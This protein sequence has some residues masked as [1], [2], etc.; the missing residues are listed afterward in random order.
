MG[1]PAAPVAILRPR[2]GAGKPGGGRGGGGE[3]DPAATGVGGYGWDSVNA[4]SGVPGMFNA[5]L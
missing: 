4:G 3:G 1:V 5:R 2:L